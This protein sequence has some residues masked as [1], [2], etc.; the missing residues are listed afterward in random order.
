MVL[1]EGLLV[2]LTNFGITCTSG[3]TTALNILNVSGVA[4]QERNLVRD[5]SNSVTEA[6][7]LCLL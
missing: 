5:L 3:S 2:F 4:Q 6:V 7:L 1:S